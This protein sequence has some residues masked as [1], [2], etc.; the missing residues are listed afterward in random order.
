ML[1]VADQEPVNEA[2]KDFMKM[3][4][5]DIE[6]IQEVRPDVS[7]VVMHN[8]MHD[9]PLQRPEELAKLIA[10]VRSLP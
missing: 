9:I 3:R 4:K 7:L 6:Y 8:T 5:Q 2:M 10:E 1:I